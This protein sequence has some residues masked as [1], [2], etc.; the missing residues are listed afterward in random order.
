MTRIAGKQLSGAAASPGDVLTWDGTNWGPAASAGGVTP[1]LNPA[2]NGKFA[3]AQTGDLT[4]VTASQVTAALDVFTPTLQ[5]LVPASGGGSV[6]FLRADGTWTSPGA[7][8]TPPAD[9]ADNG[10]YARALS[11]DLTYVTPTQVTADLNVFTNSLKGLVP[12]SGGGTTNFLRADGTWTTPTGN[13]TPPVGGAGQIAY[14]NGT[15]LSYA[16]SVKII[17][18]AAIA[19]GTNPAGAGL[20]RVP[21]NSTVLAGRDAA[22]STDLTLISWSPAADDTL[23]LGSS[24]V[25]T[26]RLTATSALRLNIGATEEFV[27]NSSTADFKDNVLS[28]GTSPS[29]S[30]LIRVAHGVA[31]IGGRNQAGLA[32]SILMAWG[33]T[34]NNRLTVGDAVTAETYFNIATGGS[35]N[36]QV[37]GSTEYTFDA[38]ALTMNAN[39]VVGAGFYST[40][41]SVAATG[42]F[43][44][45]NN[46]TVLVARNNA[47]SGDVAI[48]TWGAA[49]DRLWIGDSAGLVGANVLL[50][51]GGDFTINV[52]GTP[53]YGFDATQLTW[54]GNNSVGAGFYSG[55]GSVAGSGLLRGANNT[56][57]VA[58]RNAGGT[59]DVAALAVDGS[60]V[61][62]LGGAGATPNAV[63]VYTNATT[64][65][66][67]AI[68]GADEYVF[69][70]TQLTLNANDLVGAGSLSFSGTAAGTG[71]L[72]V[73]HAST[74]LTG[75]NN[76]NNA[77]VNLILW[78][79]TAADRL[80]I[81][82]TGVA[83]TYF[84]VATGNSYVFQAN[85]STL[86][87]LNSTALT[88]SVPL[89]LSSI[90]FGANS[91][92]AGLIRVP[93]GSLVI[94]G[95]N[96]LNTLDS[97]LFAWGTG[98]NNRITIGDTVTAE[99]YLNVATGGTFNLQ[100]NSVTEYTF[101]STS[102]T[103]NGNSMAGALFVSST[104]TTAGTGFL[105]TSSAA[106]IVV[107]RN[108]GNSGDLTLLSTDSSDHFIV[109]D[110]NV[111]AGFYNVATGG[112]HTFQVA[113][114]T[115][116][117][118]DATALTLNARNAVFTTGFISLGTNLPNAGA[119]RMANNLAVTGRNVGN[120]QNVQMIVVG[121]DS[122]VYVGD[123]TNGTATYLVTAGSIG[124]RPTGAVSD[125]ATI[126]STVFNYRAMVAQFGTNPSTSGLIGVP[127]ASNV[128]FGRNNA[129]TQN[130]PIVRW[131][132]F[133]NDLVYF[134]SSSSDTGKVANMR[135]GVDTGGAFQWE[136]NGVAV[137]AL[138][139]TALTLNA[140]NAVFTTG[141]AQFGTSPAGT[142]AIRLAN[143]LNIVA[144]NAANNADINLIRSDASDNV[145][146]GST[147]VGGDLYLDA[148]TA[149][150]VW[151][152]F[153]GGTQDYR[154]TSTIADFTDN[155]LQFGTNPAAQGTIR[156]PA[157]AGTAGVWWRNNLNTADI[158]GI[159]S[160]TDDVLYLGDS[161]T[162]VAMNLRVKTSGF[163]NML[164]NAAVEYT[165]TSTAA[166][167]KD[168][169][170][171]F[172][173]NPSGTGLIRVPTAVGFVV[174]SRNYDNS[175]D[176][177]ML[178]VSG[179]SSTFSDMIVGDGSAKGNTTL[180]LSALAQ[181][182]IQ[183]NAVNTFTFDQSKM[184]VANTTGAPGDPTGG[185]YMYAEA[186]AGKWRG[187]S[188]TVT[189]FGPAEPHCPRCGSDFAIQY[190]NPKKYGE[191]S[192][193]M[194]CLN[195]ALQKV[196]ISE[197][198]WVIEHKEVA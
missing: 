174:S 28:F 12:G 66:T 165:F 155:S 19:F 16:T 99:T 173:T 185:G 47:G 46:S 143:A 44:V 39:N 118:L 172:G 78:G 13:L 154:F 156:L 128:L 23:L 14:A 68:N 10:K 29:A 54:N 62:V 145:L 132:V 42:L 116:A 63:R 55:S 177:G 5:G 71:L 198:Q 88:L 24:A 7:G 4:Y 73:P 158:V 179:N 93:H 43:R 17:S 70:A 102:L 65:F 36:L 110:S 38:T 106:T 33:L 69:T 22:N 67:V 163:F 21:N 103:M 159:F 188:G 134:G 32:D 111:T 160:G 61:V 112:S 58:A 96:Q 152:R 142:G 95:R 127:H 89:S 178:S 171:R 1:P 119:I 60:N 151:I 94:E 138:D 76:A 86:A 64:N 53:E 122:A 181:E 164:I 157:S 175:G 113:A 15:D 148:N 105:R 11:G 114:A 130:V 162:S 41:G 141:F 101:S 126:S 167:F 190:S 51:T 91:A 100:V 150:T 193:C 80:T 135:W 97:V 184:F 107:A 48:I 40:S 187:S 45:P 87:T 196:G 84:N 146:V 8:F 125:S 197:D 153:A 182:I 161:N 72:R 180:Y 137:A 37:N 169:V 189:T 49:T 147:S 50:K 75:R 81:G 92:S 129:N 6:N 30:G 195:K 166:D 34:A 27:F 56:T 57:L 170:L 117:T 149:K 183:I 133:V 83:D 136:I 124:L 59:A 20:L 131:G 194:L 52:N 123:S 77:D 176:I 31:V 3:R 85:S 108:N 82:S 35:Y 144:H 120:T 168:N 90:S 18:N 140:R 98:A 115:V 192:G 79:V 186:G 109:G 25:P 9:P 2:D 104:G 121:T 191:F 26:V 74:D 139:V